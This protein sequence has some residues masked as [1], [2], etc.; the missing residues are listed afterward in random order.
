MPLEVE[1]ERARG[2]LP[3]ERIAE[4]R[5]AAIDRRLGGG[6]HAVEHGGQGWSHTEWFLV[7]EQLGRCHQRA[8]VAHAQ[9]LQRPGPRHPGADR[10]LPQARAA[11]RAARRLRRHRGA[12]RLG[13][14]A[15]RDHRHAHRGRLAHRRREVVRH[16]RRRRAGLHRHGQGARRRRRAAD[17]LPRRARDAGH[18]GRRRPALHA[19]LPP[20]PP[21]AALHR[22]RGARRRRHRRAWAAARTCSAA[23]SP[24]SAWASRPAAW[25]RCGG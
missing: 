13:P 23:G 25:G 9:R 1:A 20:R 22:R 11:R 24:R 2:R 16:L 10:P 7:E 6:L 14:V 15:D 5:H 8:V 4:I 18:R 3:A 19:Q 17:A 12:R 21:D